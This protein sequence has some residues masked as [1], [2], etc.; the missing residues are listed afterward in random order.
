M[1]SSVGNQC[2]KKWP[3]KTLDFIESKEDSVEMSHLG[4]N[5][6]K[7]KRKLDMSKDEGGR[8]IQATGSL[9]KK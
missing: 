2:F 5:T 4:G 3:N 8:K 1:E 6:R 7:S 9:T